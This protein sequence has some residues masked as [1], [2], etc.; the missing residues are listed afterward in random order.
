MFFYFDKDILGNSVLKKLTFSIAKVVEGIDNSLTV[1]PISRLWEQ[2][3]E[4]ERENLLYDVR[5]IYNRV[6]NSNTNI[7]EIQDEYEI[8]LK[9]I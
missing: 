5:F 1:F 9:Q 7:V 4:D 3:S 8:G 2:S 6:T